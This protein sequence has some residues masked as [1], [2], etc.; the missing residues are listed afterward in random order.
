MRNRDLLRKVLVAGLLTVPTVFTQGAEADTAAP[1]NETI[2]ESETTSFWE[3]GFGSGFRSGTENFGVSVGTGIGLEI[4]GS[5]SRHDMALA[6][7][8]YGYVL[9]DHLAPG[10]WYG[11]NFEIGAEFAAGMQFHPKN[12]YIFGLM[13]SFRYHFIT[14][15]AW[16]PFVEAGAGPGVTDIGGPDLS[17]KFQF[18]DYF[19]G[20]VNWFY[21]ESDVFSAGVRF[22]HLSNAGIKEP[23]FGV[24]T[25]MVFL[26][27]KRFF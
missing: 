7:V 11:G 19:G 6:F 1:A 18:M 14:D 23:N 22:I 16:V 20:G 10:R 25:A 9:T 2:T 15:S 24:N 17:T 21:N 12:A 8:Q 3:N 5:N 26:G 13:P 4:L 27:W